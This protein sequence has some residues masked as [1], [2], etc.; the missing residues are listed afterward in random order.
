MKPN[1]LIISEIDLSSDASLGVKKKVMA[2]YNAFDKLGCNA[3]LLCLDKGEGVLLHNDEKIVI[4]E[5]QSKDY[6]S[7]VKTFLSAAKVCKDK[8]IDFC[9]IRYPLAGWAFLKMVKQLHRVC[10]VIIEIPTYP[11]DKEASENKNIVGILD[12][13]QD[14]INRKRLQNYVNNI[15]TFSDDK[16]IFNIDCI[17]LKNGVNVD[18]INYLGDKLNYYGDIHL[19]GVALVINAHGYDRVINGLKS[20]YQND[21]LNQRKVY[22][23]IVGEGPELGNLLELC[24]TN[25]VEKYVVFHGKKFGEELDHVISDSQ[26]GVAFL[27]GHRVGTQKRSALK[28]R[29]YCAMGLPFIGS[30]ED[31]PFCADC[32]DFYKLFPANDDPIDIN[33]VVKF[34][35]YI[36]AHPEIHKQMREYAEENLTWEK[37]LSKVMDCID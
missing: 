26:I 33:E 1:V 23:D 28:T 35:E 2:Q 7:V 12:Y 18:S 31:D 5:K 13:K 27:G 32:C 37:Q 25:N 19:V 9:Y 15:V 14:R 6:F 16:K 11:Y 10:K 17:N 36:D 34:A 30:A 20:Y 22:F 29:E 8:R 3:Y 24:R 4:V 21:S